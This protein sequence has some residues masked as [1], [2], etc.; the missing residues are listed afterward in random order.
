M[1]GDVDLVGDDGAVQPF[2]E[3]EVGVRPE[4]SSQSVKVPGG[5][6]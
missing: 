1:P 6:P 4:T 3:E 2:V 5:A